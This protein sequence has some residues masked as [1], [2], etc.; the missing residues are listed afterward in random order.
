[1]KLDY[2]V[3]EDSFDDT[4]HIRTMSEQ[5]KVPGGGM[6]FATGGVSLLAGCIAFATS[7]SFR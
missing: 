7:R 6:L 5:A 2:E 3:I 1:M 4:T